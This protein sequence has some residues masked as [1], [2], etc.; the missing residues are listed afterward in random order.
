MG[1]EGRTRRRLRRIVTVRTTNCVLY[2]VPSR[3][4]NFANLSYIGT[5]HR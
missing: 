4:S 1:E 5:G 2:H 3:E